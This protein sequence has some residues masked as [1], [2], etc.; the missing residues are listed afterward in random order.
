MK[1]IV[2]HSYNGDPPTNK[3]L[4]SLLGVSEQNYTYIVATVAQAKQREEL[5]PL[6]QIVEGKPQI[7]FHRFLRLQINRK[8]LTRAEEKVALQRAAQAIAKD[9]PEVAV[10]LKNDVYSWGDA[11]AELAQ[12]GID[13]SNGIPPKLYNFLVNP[14][15]GQLLQSFQGLYRNMQQQYGRQTFEE[16]ANELLNNNY[17]PTSL[18]VMEGFTFLTP[19]QQRFLQECHQRGATVHILIPYRDAQAYGFEI[20]QRTYY[21]KEI[22]KYIV[23]PQPLVLSTASLIRPEKLAQL[24]QG[25]FAD[26]AVE[27]GEPEEIS[28]VTLESYSHRNREVAA[29][30]KR[31]KEYL[32]LGVKA[33]D[34]AIVTRVRTEFQALLQEEAE[35]QKLWDKDG[36]K[37]TLGIQPR[38]LLLTPLGRFVLT[39]YEIWQQNSLQM[40]IDQFEAILASGWLG[41]H[42]QATTEQ[43]NAVKFHMFARCSNRDT[44]QRS[45]TNLLSLKQTLPHGSRLPAASVHENTINLWQRAIAKLEEICQKLF[46]VGE[47]TIG[48]HVEYLLDELNYLAPEEML[49]A[50]REILERIGVVLHELAESAS[51]PIS[52]DEFGDIL[53]S[54]VQERTPNEKE[55]KDEPEKPQQ[56]WVTTPEGIDGYQKDVVFFLG[57]DNQRVPRPYPEPWPFYINKIDEHQEKERYFFLAVVLSA[58]QRLH[59]SYAQADEEQKYRSSLY[60]EEA[61]AVLGVPIDKKSD[62]QE[63]D[64]LKNTPTQSRS[65]IQARRKNYH[66]AEIAHFGLCPFRY[67]LER[68]DF[69]ARQY[70]DKFQMRFLAQGEW[71]NLVFQHLARQGTIARSQDDIQRN[72]LDAMNVTQSQIQDKFPGLRDLD[73]VAVKR[74]VQNSLKWE[75]QDLYKKNSYWVSVKSGKKVGYVITNED[76]TVQVEVNVRYAIK[77]GNYFKPYIEDFKREEWLK[78]AKKSQDQ[79]VEYTEVDNVKVFASQEDAVKWWE[80][81]TKT[82]FYY[83]NSRQQ[84]NKFPKEQQQNYQKQQEKIR[85]L[86][87]AIEAGH[88]PKH[89]GEHCLYCPVRTECLGLSE[90]DNS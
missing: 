40:D 47:Q 28:S 17:Q 77:K 69:K 39:L 75:A 54:L 55:D 56:I 33:E 35:L 2:L 1:R 16:A 21:G 22:S 42:L 78:P 59:L 25:L 51:L 57:V 6:H 64:E 88:Y 7:V 12:R 89:F 70:R 72:F 44:W 68:L 84:T 80:D 9:D 29:C 23:N 60:M 26:G 66:L 65:L 61:S 18:I 20:M 50:E 11:L 90:E 14:S 67:K 81:A 3:E 74:Y 15:V 34:I 76:R 5:A 82:A 4:L 19:V 32:L 86:I 37:V 63:I 43:F 73:W 83:E 52:P 13:L 8:L 30:I 46:S 31:I 10:Q 71:I 79:E 87:Q 41:A 53:N 38:Q 48:K 24:Q 49:K 58:K 62:L 85:E 45:L 36:H 27:T